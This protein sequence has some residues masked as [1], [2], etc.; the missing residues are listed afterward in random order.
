MKRLL[1]IYGLLTLL[2]LAFTSCEDDDFSFVIPEEQEVPSAKDNLPWPLTQYMDAENYRPGDDFYLYCNGKYWQN[3]SMGNKRV[4]GFFDTEMPEAL[5][6]LRTSVSNPVYDQLEAHGNV[7]VTNAQ[8]YAFLK[9]FY[10]K[11]DGIQSYEDAF[12]VAGELIMAGTK[13]VFD[14]SPASDKTVSIHL[15]TS[16]P[17]D[18][19]GEHLAFLESDDPDDVYQYIA[20]HP[21]DVD[22]EEAYYK[23]QDYWNEHEEESAEYE[24][25]ADELLKKYLV[26]ALGLKAEVLEFEDGF[27]NWL[28]IPLEELKAY[29]KMKVF[30]DF[31]PYANQQGFDFMTERAW[32]FKSPFEYASTMTGLLKQYLDDRLLIERYVSAGLKREVET[33]CEEIRDAF[34]TRIENLAW[35]VLPPRPMPSGK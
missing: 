4:V 17:F 23:Q 19:R 1:K 6:Q 12:R 31:A 18:V 30:Q 2:I 25:R 14:V 33:L 24:A 34:C 27:K 29:L 5:K 35:I 9:P 8:F 13:R 15:E 10:K 16:G 20:T 21:V 28:I 26:P 7:Q 11:I 32:P 22:A 3:A